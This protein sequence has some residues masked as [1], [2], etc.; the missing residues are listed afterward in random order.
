MNAIIQL[1]ALVTIFFVRVAALLGSSKAKK[2]VAEMDENLEKW[3]K[4]MNM[5]R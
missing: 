3:M 1:L 4:K 2:E 5:L